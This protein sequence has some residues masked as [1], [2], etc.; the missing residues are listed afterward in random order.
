M[1]DF[2]WDLFYKVTNLIHEGGSLIPPSWPKYLPEVPLLILSHWALG[3]AY[4]FRGEGHKCLDHSIKETASGM[5]MLPWKQLRSPHGDADAQSHRYSSPATQCPLEFPGSF[6][7]T[8]PPGS[9]SASQSGYK[10]CGQ[11]PPVFHIHCF[12]F[13]YSTPKASDVSS[14]PIF[15]TIAS[16]CGHYL[17]ILIR[18]FSLWYL[19]VYKKSTSFYQRLQIKASQIIYNS[20]AG[21]LTSY[22]TF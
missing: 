21:H 18:V 19:F 12:L 13:V 15:H 22:D 20:K 10:H 2:L 4:K 7:L 9:V 16:Y 3:S 8:I 6:C 5:R 14:P 11:M 17:Y 1:R